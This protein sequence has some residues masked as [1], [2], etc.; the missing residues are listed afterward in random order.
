MATAIHK[1]FTKWKIFHHQALDAL[2]MV[3]AQQPFEKL[4]YLYPFDGLVAVVLDLN[5]DVDLLAVRIDAFI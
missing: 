4:S 1:K 3:G 2:D 5:V